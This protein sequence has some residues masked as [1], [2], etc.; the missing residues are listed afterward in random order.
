M[1]Y[2][3]ISE[4]VEAIRSA[5]DNFNQ[6][7]DLRP[8]LDSNGNPVMSSGNF[9]VVFKMQDVNTQQQ[10]AVKCFTREQEKREEHY[11]KIAEE[12]EFTSSPYLLHFRYMEDELF[13]DTT[14]SS[15]NDF[16]VLVMDWAEGVT[17]DNYLKAHLHDSYVLQLLAYRFC[18]MGA[19]LLSQPFAHGDLKPDNILVRKD[20][21]LVLV[22]YDGMFVPALQDEN[23]NELGSPDFRHPLRT[24]A[25]FNEHIDDFAIA[26]IALSLKAISLQPSLY[27]QFATAD[28]LLL[29]ASDYRDIGK[30]TALQAIL[31]LSSDAELA[32]LFS[33]FLLASSLNSLGMLS[34]RLFI[35]QQPEKPKEE[36]W[37]T[38][39]TDEDRQN[40]VEDEFGVLYS[41]DGMRLI[42]APYNLV[43]YQIKEGTK[44][45]CN[46]AFYW[47]E[48]LQDIHI[49]NSVT[50]IGEDAFRGCSSLQS[51]HIPNSVNHI[52]YSAFEDCSSLQNINIP[53]S[54]THIDRNPF[55]NCYQLRLTS[56][57]PH[58]KVINGLL[59][60]SDGTL[61]SC[62]SKD[63]H[64]NIPNSVTH[65]GNGAFNRCKSLQNIN[66][67]NSVTHIG[68]KAFNGCN[69]LQNINIPNSV[70]HIGDSAFWKCNSLQNIN[71]SN[72]VTHIGS[73]A[74]YDCK[75]LQNIN[76][77]NSVN[78]IGNSAFMECRSLQS[79]HIPNS[80]TYI[81]SNPFRCC[82]QLRLTSE[83][84]L[85]K[86]INGLLISSDGTLISC[87]S[88]DTHINIP[89]SLTHIG[90]YAFYGCKALQS[91]HIPNSVTHIGDY[92]FLECKALQ[93]ISLPNSLT[94]IGNYAFFGCKALQSIH[95]PN[96]VTHIGDYAF[97]VCVALQ[98]INIPNSVTH[99]GDSAFW[100]C[101]SLQNINMPNSVTQ[102]GCGA[103]SWCE[104]LQNIN[105]PN[106]VTYI[107]DEAFSWCKALQEI[108][109]PNS[110]TY[111]GINPF[112]NCTQLRLTSDNPHFKV[113]N[114]LLISSDGTL[115][116]CCSEDTY[117]HIPN[118]VTQIGDSSFS[119]CE[120]L[121]DIHIPNSV[122]HI[123]RD[124][125]WCCSSLQNIHIP[126]SVTYIG[127]SA[128]SCCNAL[129]TIHIPK[130]S[131]A[132]FMRLLP[133]EFHDKLVEI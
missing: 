38:D 60:S 125:F 21:S 6:L 23:A 11:R 66:I 78:H 13:V 59:I 62:L 1:Q 115:I 119:E 113:I 100:N 9:A 73:S 2:P 3:L 104:A 12:L 46:E 48:E 79:I 4:Y 45:I 34:F 103:F 118:S 80:V 51:I 99:I 65:I 15:T 22:D 123:G 72:S 52:G 33:A 105:I 64:I 57:N 117:I 89:N 19:W 84:F 49:P 107:G 8:V 39:V 93:S 91:I 36:I 67:P 131:M 108:N 35:L 76:I 77:P 86:V 54:V 56:D 87:L 31:A 37:R 128:F 90:N 83:N 53:N 71:M 122:A 68:D 75:A 82:P 114:G 97:S 98:N 32:K 94:H 116:S 74:F 120:I 43:S 111:I 16:P 69:A 106:S 29:S 17:L 63:T 42:E 109:I 133:E 50:Q 102:I 24:E 124:A 121:Q 85:F 44:V 81:G 127:D 55:C 28:R 112:L 14:Q 25:T 20:G 40:A 47:R 96:S 101:N 92:A 5:E 26:S 130:G 70:T 18:R 132:K 7:S 110:V 30:S 129:Q 58:F 88:K 95:I 41:A 27:N 61:I 10:Y 126:N